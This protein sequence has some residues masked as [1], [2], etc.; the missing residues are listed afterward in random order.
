[1]VTEISPVWEANFA[2]L[3]ELSKD[4][5]SLVEVIQLYQEHSNLLE[6]FATT[7]SLIWARRNQLKVGETT[8]SLWKINSM[9]IDNL[10]ELQ[11][12]M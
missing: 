11:R 9:A 6:L 3:I 2:W 5:N 8:A 7:V 1:M 4:C 10:Q 12:E